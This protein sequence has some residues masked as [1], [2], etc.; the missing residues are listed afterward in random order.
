MTDTPTTDS[1]ELVPFD[2]PRIDWSDLSTLKWITCR[3]HPTARYLSKNPW[4][5]SLHFIR[6]CD[7]MLEGDPSF[8]PNRPD[9]VGSLECDCL[10]SDL[11]V[12]L[13]DG[14]V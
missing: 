13:T 10:F 7:E 8:R 3:H 9:G 6:P 12:V 11:V 2:D 5:R 1:I 14:E 4:T